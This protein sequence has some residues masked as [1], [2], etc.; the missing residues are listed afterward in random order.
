MFNVSQSKVK[1]WQMC[2]RAYHYKYVEKIRA[3]RKKRPLT[4]GTI[5]HSMLEEDANGRDPFKVLDKAEKEQGRLFAAEREMF[6]DIITDIRHIMTDYFNYWPDDSLIYTKIDGR[7]A[8]HEFN[9]EL[10]P[11]INWN[12]KIDAVVRAKRLRW[13][14]DHKSFGKQPSDDELW[15]NLQSATY[16]RA[17]D[18]LGWKPVDGMLW[19]FIGSK[20]PGNIQVNQDGSLSKKKINSLPSVLETFLEERGLPADA[21]LYQPLRKSLEVNRQNYYKRVFQ[22]TSRAVVDNVMEDFTETA[23]EMRELHGTKKMRTIGRHCSW[24]DFEPLCRTALTNGD[25]D[26]IKQKD[27]KPNVKDADPDEDKAANE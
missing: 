3:K 1:T 19:N 26:Y 21:P 2:K 23:V 6:G 27:Y 10:V 4:F 15:R 16:T 25:V 13:V 14:T 7:R 20:V 24:C 18:I 22:P 11:G 5:I 12:G 8:E 17:I 9:I